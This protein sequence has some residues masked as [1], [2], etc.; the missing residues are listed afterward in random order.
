MTN[1]GAGLFLAGAEIHKINFITKDSAFA[2]FA[3]R[4]RAVVP[5]S[6]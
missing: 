3:A 2:S 1:C 4:A 5:S 6:E